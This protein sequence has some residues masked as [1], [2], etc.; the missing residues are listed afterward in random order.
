[1][2]EATLAGRQPRAESDEPRLAAALAALRRR[3]AGRLAAT[4]TPTAS[5]AATSRID[6]VRDPP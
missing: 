3:T 1:M 6:L 4:P 5:T 2:R